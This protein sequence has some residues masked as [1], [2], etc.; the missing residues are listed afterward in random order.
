MRHNRLLMGH[1]FV[2]ECDL[3]WH[4]VTKIGFSDFKIV[5]KPFLRILY[6]VYVIKLVKSDLMSF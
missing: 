1:N 6:V 3:T 4:Y 5:L 2:T